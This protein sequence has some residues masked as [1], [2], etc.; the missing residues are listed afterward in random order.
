MG[1]R[2]AVLVTGATGHQG[3]SAARHLVKKGHRVRALTRQAASPK[4][5]ALAAA[6]VELVAGDLDDPA[7]IDRALTGMD[8]VFLIT[9]PFESGL[10]AETR[11]AMAVVDAAQA[12]GAHVVYTSVANADR[13]TGIPH[14]DSKFVVEQHIRARGIPATILAPAYFMENVWFSLPQLRQGVY[15]SALSAQRPLMQVAVSDIGAATAA[16]L[17]DRAKH[18]GRRYDLAGD[19]LSAEE[20]AAILSSVTG[21]PIHYV[22]VPIDAIRQTMGEDGVTMYEW[23]EHTGYAIDRDALRGAFPDVAW[24]SFKTWAAGQ[25][26]ASSMH[27]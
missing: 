22:Q 18:T 17:E 3:G 9:T 4:A 10:D 12:A 2:L 5:Q 20:E 15:G 13:R 16:V 6:G 23:F 26:W 25:D 7:A 14:F 21:R 11:Q 24:T 27:V 19:E 1:E 8:A